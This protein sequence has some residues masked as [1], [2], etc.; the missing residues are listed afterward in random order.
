MK[1]NDLCE[2]L[3][4]EVEEIQKDF[5]YDKYEAGPYTIYDCHKHGTNVYSFEMILGRRGIYMGGDIHGLTFRV[6]RGLEFLAG[7]DINYYI[8]SKLEQFNRDEREIDE[9]LVNEAVKEFL[10]QALEDEEIKCTEC[11][12][13]GQADTEKVKE[14]IA[15]VTDETVED[16]GLTDE[17]EEFDCERCDG[18]G[19]IRLD[20]DDDISLEDV[21]KIYEQNELA[22]TQLEDPH[23]N[24]SDDKKPTHRAWEFKESL[25]YREYG[26]QREVYEKMYDSGVCD[27]CD[28]P[29]IDRPATQVI[30]SLY[31]MNYA[32]KRILEQN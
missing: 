31:M 15:E 21:E 17:I 28:M 26:D 14:D 2:K 11:D 1:I 20:V 18:T 6:A 27:G 19:N 8:Y 30:F 7:N 4:K 12:G 23:S 16:M 24:Y 9:D 25:Q 32:A 13:T 22:Y 29:T 5:V 10:L 3:K